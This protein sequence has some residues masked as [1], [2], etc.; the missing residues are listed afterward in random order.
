MYNVEKEEKYNIYGG[1]IMIIQSISKNIDVL[2]PGEIDLNKISPIDLIEQIE[3]E[4]KLYYFERIKRKN[5]R[6]SARKRFNFFSM[7]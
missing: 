1:K 3:L 5:K 2:I 7:V 4:N 6:L